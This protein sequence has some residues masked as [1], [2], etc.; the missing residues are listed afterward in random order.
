MI[1]RLTDTSITFISEFSYKTEYIKTG[2][3]NKS[4]YDAKKAF[5]MNE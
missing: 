1:F 5:K 4:Q 2:V 3:L